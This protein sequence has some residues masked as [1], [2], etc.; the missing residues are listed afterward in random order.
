[1]ICHKKKKRRI[2]FLFTL[3]RCGAYIEQGLKITLILHST[4]YCY[5]QHH[6]LDIALYTRLAAKH[7]EITVQVLTILTGVVIVNVNHC[8][9]SGGG[10]AEI[11]GG[12]SVFYII[13]ICSEEFQ[14][15]QRIYSH[16]LPV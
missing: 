7:Q 13:D 8:V 1:M 14:F 4:F 12:R 6:S 15:I 9:R 5:T 2:K 3:F 10:V 16:S 11:G